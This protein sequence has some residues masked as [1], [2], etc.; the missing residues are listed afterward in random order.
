MR[1]PQSY[2]EIKSYIASRIENP[3]DVEDLL[4]QVFLEFFR[5][6]SKGLNIDNPKFYL[7]GIAK[8][9]IIG[10]LRQKYKTPKTIELD[11]ETTNKISYN[12]YCAKKH[13]RVEDLHE[14][15][16]ELVSN[17]P[18]KAKEAVKLR[19][20]ENLSYKEASQ[21]ANCSPRIFYDRFYEGMK[22]LK[23]KI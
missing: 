22:I 11:A 10:Y 20:I 2:S 7:F 18:S 3:D 16:N 4:Q 8:K 21:K 5:S 12:K 9:I 14:K 15:I 1:S 23:Q 13:F 17:L 6:E 19:L